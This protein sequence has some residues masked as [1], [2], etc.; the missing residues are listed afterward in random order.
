M[1]ELLAAVVGM[2]L[3]H[4]PF[5]D[6]DL[7]RLARRREVRQHAARLQRGQIGAQNPSFAGAIAEMGAQ[8]DGAE[9]FEFGGERLRQV[10][11]ARFGRR[12]DLSAG[13]ARR[14]DVEGDEVNR[15]GGLV[16]P[17]MGDRPLLQR[18]ATRRVQDAVLTGGGI[19]EDLAGRDGEDGRTVRVVVDR[20]DAVFGDCPEAGPQVAARQALDRLGRKRRIAGHVVGDATGLGR[21]FQT[22]DHPGGQPVGQVSQGGRRGEHQ[23]GDEEL[24]VS[25]PF[26]WSSAGRCSPWA[27]RNRRRDPA[28]S[29]STRPRSSR[30]SP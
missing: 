18:E 30:S 12:R 6:K 11:G 26:R 15:L 19:L 1:A 14:M 8:I 5:P 21:A 4:R 29:G 22:V 24:H 9:Q 23:G 27:F 13:L 16:L 3:G 2:M 10:D 28:G 7:K 17:P 20:H 25:L